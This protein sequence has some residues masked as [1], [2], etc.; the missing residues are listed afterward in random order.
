VREALEA[1]TSYAQRREEPLTARTVEFFVKER[2]EA[3]ELK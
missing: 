3:K 1:A 2:A